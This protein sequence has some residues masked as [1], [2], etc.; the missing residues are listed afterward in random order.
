MN[1]MPM[2][3]AGVRGNAVL[4]AHKFLGEVIREGCIAVDAT[5]GNGNDTL[6]LAQAVGESGKVIAF[7]LQRA[8]LD[9]TRGILREHG[10]EHR[11]VLIESG[12]E[13]M[14]NYIAEPVDLIIFNLG[15]LPG[16]THNNITRPETTGKALNSALALLK[17]GGRISIVVYTG[18]QGA[19]EE[20]RVVED[21]A[22]S[23]DPG[24]FGA[25]KVSFANRSAAAP[26]L[27]LIE[28][29]I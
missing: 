17:P 6:F 15:Y 27:V 3:F 14:E 2:R 28:R 5:A 20:S 16:G 13:Y 22:A 21:I 24:A 4:L 12:H 23:L 18:H 9:K 11:V 25:L 26:F 8:A 10:L 7:D 1:N 29:V 19:L